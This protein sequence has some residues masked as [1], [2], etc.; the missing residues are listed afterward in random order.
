MNKSKGTNKII[1]ASSLYILK[2]AWENHGSLMLKYIN[3]AKEMR[4]TTP[5]RYSISN[6]RRRT[7]PRPICRRAL[8]L[9]TGTVAIRS[10]APLTKKTQLKITPPEV[11]K[12]KEILAQHTL[13]QWIPTRAFYHA[14]M[15]MVSTCIF[16]NFEKKSMRSRVSDASEEGLRR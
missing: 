8:L 5:R 13:F 4:F 2:S 6:A 9:E 11:E 7:S 15:R 14:I 3:R 1:I 16:H 12:K 10:Q